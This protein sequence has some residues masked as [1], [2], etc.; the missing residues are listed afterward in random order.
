MLSLHRRLVLIALVLPLLSA[1]LFAGGSPE[2]SLPAQ[3]Q[4]DTHNTPSAP[5]E[6]FPVVIEHKYG[7][8]T[9][10]SPPAR[11]VSVGYSEHDVLLALGVIPVG[12]RD[13][14]GDQPYATWPW[15]QDELG[16]GTPQI[17]GAAELD[18]E[19]IV[20]LA[21]DLIVGVSSGMT[22]DEYALLSRIAPTLA[23]PGE[24]LDYG[25][26]W[27][28]ETL[29]IGRAVGRDAQAREI[30]TSLQTRMEQAKTDNPAFVGASAAVAFLFQNERGAFSSQDSRSRILQQLGFVTPAGYDRIAGDSFYLTISDEL[31]ELLDTDVVVWV[32]TTEDGP[33]II[34]SLPL[35]DTMRAYREGR[36]IF[37]DPLTSAA[38]SF[39]SPLSL[40]YALDVIVPGLTAAIDG[41]RSTA[42]P[43]NLR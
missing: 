34:Q 19:A 40:S 9:I 24:Y 28:E 26:P 32:S 21:P 10:P 14:Y 25:T 36:E 22:A 18:I 1:A 37:L 42:V 5:I 4:S 23:Q 30:V 2:T 29:L 41:D 39:A 7:T 8:V 16:D 15:A 11:V 3:T 38:L 12:V 35:R 17:I 27:D 43:A 20:A 33:R 31:I 13:W 6:G